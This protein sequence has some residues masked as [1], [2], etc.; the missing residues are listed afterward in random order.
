MWANSPSDDEHCFLEGVQACHDVLSEL[1][2]DVLWSFVN[3]CRGG[4]RGIVFA[5]LGVGRVGWIRVGALGPDSVGVHDHLEVLER[6]EHWN[7]VINLGVLL[8]VNH[9]LDLR[10]LGGWVEQVVKWTWGVSVGWGRVAV[11]CSGAG[12]RSSVEVVGWGLHAV[13]WSFINNCLKVQHFWFL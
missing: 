2:K 7:C 3:S 11:V 1:V 6:N 8:I 9:W 13:V 10:L 5:R 12:G 4:S